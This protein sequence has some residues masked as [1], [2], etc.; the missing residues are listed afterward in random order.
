MISSFS[1]KSLLPN[2]LVTIG[3]SVTPFVSAKAHIG[4][5]G[6]V[7]GHGHLVGIGL[8]AASSVLAGWLA[9]RED[10]KYSANQDDADE[11]GAGDEVNA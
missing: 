7:A 1:K 8:F 6:E 5:V 11:A 9:T 4:H 2:V 3:T 10:G